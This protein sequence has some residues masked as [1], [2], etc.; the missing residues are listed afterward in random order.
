MKEMEVDAAAVVIASSQWINGTQAWK[1]EGK[2][3]RNAWNPQ[4]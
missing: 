1:M 4:L 3:A 2:C